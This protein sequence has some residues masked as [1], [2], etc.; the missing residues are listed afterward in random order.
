MVTPADDKAP[1]PD[2]TASFWTIELSLERA[3]APMALWR[4]IFCIDRAGPELKAEAFNLSTTAD[5]SLAI[6]CR[7]SSP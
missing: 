6:D 2:G 3:A 7:A 5:L 4:S 1:S